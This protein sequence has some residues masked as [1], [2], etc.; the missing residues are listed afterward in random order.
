MKSKFL[1][2]TA[3]TLAFYPPELGASSAATVALYYP[4]GGTLQ[5]AATATRDS[6]S[7]TLSAAAAKGA[8]S[9]VVT[10]ATGITVGTRYLVAAGGLT[11]DV[12]VKSISGTTIYITAP[13]S[14]PMAS[15]ATYKGWLLSYALTTTHTDV[16]DQSYRAEWVYTIAT[17]A[18]QS[19]QTYDVVAALDY[20][21]T[22]LADVIARHPRISAML[23]DWQQDGDDLLETV[24]QQMVVP[25]LRARRMRPE[26]LMDKGGL[27]P[28]HVAHV[29]LHVAEHEAMLS[30]DRLEQLDVAKVNAES[31]L[32]LYSSAV[33]WQDES[34]D[35]QLDADEEHQVQTYIGISR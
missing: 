31:T 19:Q 9:V 13:L 7:T 4:G 22:T 33:D 11:V 14:A 5:A 24:W 26:L 18:Y 10:S 12:E 16:I 8:R 32:Q 20:Y 1:T 27:V 15:G 6:T 34:E 29:N 21:E 28:V 30:S 3:G 35:L 23:Y 17:V 25:A 2:D